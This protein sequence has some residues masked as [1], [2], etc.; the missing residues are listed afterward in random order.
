[1]SEQTPAEAAAE[2]AKRA[3]EQRRQAEAD[4]RAHAAQVAASTSP[5]EKTR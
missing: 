2:A 3:E 5:L 4:L 1:M